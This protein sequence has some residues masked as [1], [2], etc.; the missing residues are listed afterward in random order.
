MSIGQKDQNGAVFIKHT[1]SNEKLLDL[2][3]AKQGADLSVISIQPSPDRINR[4]RQKDKTGW[5]WAAARLMTASEYQRTH[6]HCLYLTLPLVL[7]AATFP[8]RGEYEV[9]HVC[10]KAIRAQEQLSLCYF[11]FLHL[12]YLGFFVQ[13]Q[14]FRSSARNG[15]GFSITIKGHLTKEYPSGNS[16]ILGIQIIQL[17]GEVWVSVV[18]LR[19]S[20]ISRKY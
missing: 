19:P 2:H 4:P 16:Q 13:F 18:P 8:T 7:T 17:N 10:V 5:I 12:P 3:G 15:E 20:F 1:Q 11:L 9:C 14:T 6:T